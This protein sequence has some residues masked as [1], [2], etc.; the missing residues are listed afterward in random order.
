MAYNYGSVSEMLGKMISEEGLTNRFKPIK[1][2]V[3]SGILG[4]LMSERNI[5]AN[6]ENFEFLLD[7]VTYVF[8]RNKYKSE[9]GDEQITLIS[10]PFV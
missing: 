1:Q 3:M 10:Q 4:L 8:M 5:S 2:A 6:T 7:F 9:E